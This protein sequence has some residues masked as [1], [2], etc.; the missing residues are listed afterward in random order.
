[1]ICQPLF[2]FKRVE[3]EARLE[4]FWSQFLKISGETGACI[5]PHY[6]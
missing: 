3:E 4:A 6:S 1:L 5:T 2:C